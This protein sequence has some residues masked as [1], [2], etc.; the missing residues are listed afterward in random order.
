MKPATTKMLQELGGFILAGA[1]GP[2]DV[3][4]MVE[5]IRAARRYCWVAVYKMNR[6]EFVFVAGTGSEK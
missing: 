6:T 3:K 4:T 1:R 2:R 5:M